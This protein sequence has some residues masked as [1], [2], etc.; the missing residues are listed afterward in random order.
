MPTTLKQVL[1]ADNLISV[2]QGITN[3]L[4]EDIIPAGFLNTTR[5]IEGNQG[6][7]RKVEGTRQTARLA[8][9]ASPSK[10]REMKG[11]S[12]VAVTLLS[13]KEHIYHKPE[14]L[15]NLKQIDDRAKQRRA[16]QEIARQT[17]NFRQL[18]DNLRVASVFSALTLGHIYFDADG[19]LLPSSSGAVTTIDYGIPAGNM[20]QLDVLGDGDII[21]ASWGTAGTAI[22]TQLQELKA[23][24]RQKTG[25]DLRHAFYGANILDY[26]L[27]NDYLNNVISRNPAYA[28]SFAEG[29]I[30]NG[31]L[32]F[33]W[34]PFRDA[35]YEDADGDIQTFTGGDTVVFTPE[36][37]SDWYE[38]LQGSNLVPT[39][40]GRIGSSGEDMLGS[41]RDVNGMYSYASVQ[42]DP[43]TIK[44]VAGDTFLPVIKVP[45]AVFIADVTP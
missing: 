27:G 30:P 37:S 8:E 15:V 16:R 42:E 1:G 41:L 9:Y 11:I 17:R 6:T 43:V 21:G 4:P 18:F 45:N 36:V 39:S 20:N 23:A 40:I 22:H 3:G 35:F 19:N 14:I 31:F 5:D 10:L 32:G 44:H 33:D 7:Y 13:T 12:E 34:I 38:V 2:I 28:T 26:I 24:A 25:Y 29:E